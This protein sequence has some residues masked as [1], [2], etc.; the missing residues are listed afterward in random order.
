M[1]NGIQ[2]AGVSPS[3]PF[4]NLIFLSIS[5]ILSFG[6]AVCLAICLFGFLHLSILTVVWLICFDQSVL[7]K[8]S[9]LISCVISPLTT[10]SH[11]CNFPSKL[12][13]I[14]AASWLPFSPSCYYF[15]HQQPVFFLLNTEWPLLVEKILAGSNGT[16]FSSLGD[17]NRE[18][19]L[20]L[21]TLWQTLCLGAIFAPCSPS[22][23]GKWRQSAGGVSLLASYV[24]TVWRSSIPLQ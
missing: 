5:I 18:I 8:M 15:S 16:S 21:A 9:T 11:Q 23:L 6:P 2:P 22:S 3:P 4:F 1:P 7:R 14:H 20:A 17:I 12:T 13:F 24:F 19:S 10:H